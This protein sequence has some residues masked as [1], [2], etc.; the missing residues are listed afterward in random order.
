M[1]LAFTLAGLTLHTEL[2]P[3]AA[4]FYVILAEGIR[5]IALATIAKRY[6]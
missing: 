3:P 2:E 1:A 4:P 5:G 6:A